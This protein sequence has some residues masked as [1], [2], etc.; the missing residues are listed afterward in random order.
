MTFNTF[1]LLCLNVKKI[2]MAQNTL[3]IMVRGLIFQL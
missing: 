1:Y 2:K 3:L